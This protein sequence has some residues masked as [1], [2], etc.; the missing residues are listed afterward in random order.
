MEGPFALSH[1]RVGKKLVNGKV[2]HGFWTSETEGGGRQGGAL[3]SRVQWFWPFLINSLCFMCFWSGREILVEKKRFFEILN[4]LTF[5]PPKKVESWKL[6]KIS[7]KLGVSKEVEFCTYLKNVQTS[8]VWQK[9]KFFFRKNLWE[10][11]DE[12]VLHIFEISSKF[13]FFWYPLRRIMKK[14]FFNSYK[15]A[16]YFFGSWKVKKARN[17]SI[18]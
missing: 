5:F 14:F 16:W 12:G 10:L 1:S 7:S 9:G 6:K 13:R 2:S 17:R 18:L 11:L 8:W 4:G 15:G 3:E